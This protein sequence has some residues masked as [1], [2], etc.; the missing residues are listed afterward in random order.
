[1]PD[2]FGVDT[3]RGLE[4]EGSTKKRIY[5]KEVAEHIVSV[6]EVQGFDVSGNELAEAFVSRSIMKLNSKTQKKQPPAKE[7]QGKH[8]KL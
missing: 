2:F 8:P 5:S 6:L 1:M 4:T 3:P 7:K